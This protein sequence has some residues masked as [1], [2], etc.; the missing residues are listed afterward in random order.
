[1]GGPRAGSTGRD[2]G[3]LRALLVTTAV[4]VAAGATWTPAGGQSPP[5]SPETYQNPVH[6]ADVP[7]PFVL[8]SGA[9]YYAYATHRGLAN[10][11]ILRSTDLVSWTD[12]GTALPLLPAWA[13]GPYVWAPSV[14]ARPDGRHVLYY[15]VRERASGLFCVS[16][17]VSVS[18]PH[19]PFLDRSGGPMVCQR[20]Q[21][22]TIDPSP[23]VDAEGTAWLLHK[24]E[25]LERRLPTR[26]WS[27]QLNGDGTALVGP[28]HLLLAT[29]QPWE[30]PI[31]ENPAMVSADGR[32]WLLY[33]GN[34]WQSRD[35]AVGWATC[36]SPAGP[37]TKPETGPLFG[38]ANGA[39]G[40][41][42]VELF[43]DAGGDTWMAYHAWAD[44]AVG[45]PDGVRSLRIDRITFAEG[46]PWVHAPTT[47]PT[48]F[49]RL[50]GPPASPPVPSPVPPAPAPPA[51][52]GTPAAPGPADPAAAA[53]APAPVPVDE[54]PVEEP[55]PPEPDPLPDPPLAEPAAAAGGAP[56]AGGPKGPLGTPEGA[57]ARPVP[58]RV[59]PPATVPLLVTTAEDAGRGPAPAAAVALLGV[60]A[61]ALTARLARTG[62]HA[63]TRHGT[64]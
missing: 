20:D 64:G 11:Q 48:R 9:A 33:S 46:R 30:G 7:D 45:Y 37:C 25:G 19:G 51:P 47:G 14:L 17:A 34:R 39:A 28:R 59:A 60:V 62:I 50:P 18:G 16:R 58:H 1:M 4:V 61:A 10:I 42:G 56:P 12:L 26:L 24:S 40:P 35:Y 13:T 32:L 22:G 8:R 15:A 55:G 52:P 38:S 21:G 49:D 31:I 27:Q 2:H 54:A 29:D 36:E 41:G 6:A 23:F 44:G 57:T 3:A 63:A 5:P 43:T 53:P